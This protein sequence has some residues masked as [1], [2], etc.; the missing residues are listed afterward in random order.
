[1]L[2]FFSSLSRFPYG[3]FM[4]ATVLVLFGSSQERI[5]AAEPASDFLK[6]LRAAGYFDTAITYLDRLDQY[7]GVDQSMLDAVSL[8]KAQTFLD[9]AGGTRNAEMRDEMLLN[10]ET[11]LTEFLKQSSHPR[12]PEARMQLGRLQMVRGMQLMALETD[13]DKRTRARESFVA[14]AATFDLIVEQLREKLKEMQGAKIDVDQNP[15][16]AVLRDRYRGEFLL[17]LSSAGEYYEKGRAS[18]GSDLCAVK[19]PF[20]G[21]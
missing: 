19:S 21:V 8:E 14:A 15:E 11:E 17:A 4:I 20:I 2:K 5:N 13:D 10:A 7:S 18:R 6:R 1:M 12:V 3:L 9:A 16:Q